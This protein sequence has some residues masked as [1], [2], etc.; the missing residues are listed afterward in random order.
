MPKLCTCSDFFNVNK[1]V[2]FTSARLKIEC[3]E[4]LLQCTVHSGTNKNKELHNAIARV[5]F[6]KVLLSF[7]YFYKHF[8]LH[9]NSTKPSEQTISST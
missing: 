3:S 4:L 9:K 8:L 1:R 2:P 5:N 6:S 7:L